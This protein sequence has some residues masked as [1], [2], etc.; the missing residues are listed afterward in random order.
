[1]E[2]ADLK[3]T[4]DGL[5]G[6]TEPEV[7]C[8]ECFDLLDRY[9]ELGL[10]VRPAARSTRVCARSSAASRRSGDKPPNRCRVETL[11]DLVGVT[12]PFRRRGAEDGDAAG[13]G[14]V[15]RGDAD[16]RV[17]E[18]QNVTRSA[19]AEPIQREQ[20]PLGVRLRSG[21]VLSGDGERDVGLEPGCGEH[22][23]EH[24]APRSRDDPNRHAVCGSDEC[25]PGLS[26]NRRAVTGRDEVPRRALGDHVG[27]RWMIGSEPGSHALLVGEPRQ[28][29]EVLVSCDRSSVG[30][31]QVAVDLEPDRLVERERSVEVEED[32]TRQGAIIA[33]A[34]NS[35]TCG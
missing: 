15:R 13:S 12:Q 3:H 30:C 25:L 6:P 4:L 14:R 17:F 18:D 11:D 7:G 35:D 21:D 5:L 29:A 34:S 8:D 28:P 32:R 23:L 22:G 24:V 1:M 31:V 27:Y 10:V 26:R 9:V 2:R 16:R 19:D 20:I 33:V